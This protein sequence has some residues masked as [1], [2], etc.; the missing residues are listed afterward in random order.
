MTGRDS[1]E[2]G[3][4]V[5]STIEAAEMEDSFVAVE[6]EDLSLPHDL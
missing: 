1:E 5:E 3:D 2:V 6:V 4:K